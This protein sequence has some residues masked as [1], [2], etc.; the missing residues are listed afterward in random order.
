MAS[1]FSW[2]R[3]LR[4]YYETP[5]GVFSSDASSSLN[6]GKITAEAAAARRAVDQRTVH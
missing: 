3:H 6:G 4:F 2:A 5:A 1:D